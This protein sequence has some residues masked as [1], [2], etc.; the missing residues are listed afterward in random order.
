MA[1][2][3]MTIEEFLNDPKHE[4]EAKFFR[5]G[6]KKVVSEMADDEKKKLDKE[7]KKKGNKGFFDGM[8][9]FGSAKEDEEEEEEEEEESGDK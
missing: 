7:G 2:K 6:V 1:K 4:E 9:L 8:G 5:A 3:K